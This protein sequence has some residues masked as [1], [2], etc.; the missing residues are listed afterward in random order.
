[1]TEE[2]GIKDKQHKQTAVTQQ[3]LMFVING[4]NVLLSSIRYNIRD[5]VVV[6]GLFQLL[7]STQIVNVLNVTRKV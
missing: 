6:A 3:N 7:P 5:F 1:L 4:Q 2:K